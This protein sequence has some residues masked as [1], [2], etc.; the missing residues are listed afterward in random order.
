MRGGGGGRWAGSC[1]GTLHLWALWH[2]PAEAQLWERAPCPELL[3][4]GTGDSSLYRD[5]APQRQDGGFA[6]GAEEEG[7]EG[8]RDATS[9]RFDIHFGAALWLC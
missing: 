2:P 1:W 3:Q 9:V 7:T 4:S 5:I 8:Y 6:G